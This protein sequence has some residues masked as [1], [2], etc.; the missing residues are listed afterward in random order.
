M[1]NDFLKYRVICE[2]RVNLNISWTKYSTLEDV[3]VSDP[4]AFDYFARVLGNE[5]L[6][7]F[8]TRTSRARYYSMVC[9]GIYICEQ[10]LMEQ[11]MAVTEKNILQAFV[12]YEKYWA[13]SVA[14]YYGG[15]L[16]GRER[17]LRGKKGAVAAFA[18]K[19]IIAL[20]SRY[21]LLSRQLELGGMGAYR[22]SLEGLGLIYDTTLRLTQ[23]GRQLAKCFIKNSSYDKLILK[24]LKQ[25]K[26]ILK[27]GRATVRSFGYHARL[28]GF[29]D[30]DE[31]YHNE[32]QELLREYILNN[33][34]TYMP[35]GLIYFLQSENSI[36]TIKNICGHKSGHDQQ[37]QVVSTYRTILA[38][39]ELAIL[40]N[41]ILCSVI[42]LA[43]G[44]AGQTTILDCANNCKV[45]IG[46][47][48]GEKIRNLMSSEKYSV[49]RNSFHGMDFDT[50][51]KKQAD[52]M[53]YEHFIIDLIHYH[54]NIMIRRRTGEWMYIEGSKVKVNNG[55]D[56]TTKSKGKSYLHDFKIPNIQTIIDDTGWRP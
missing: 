9:Y 41:D 45:L 38:F 36:E 24:A 43:Y 10:F 51:L 34:K 2:R 8:T 35:A 3:S 53:D 30:S 23:Q 4:L 49:I 31:T 55:Y 40:L 11:G 32:E 33:E 14:T 54:A 1:V 18:N 48:A 25:K 15:D 26:L 21:K 27:N 56:Y 44:N 7:H 16:S 50:F 12:M 13:Y 20:D 22:S 52:N 47:A 42:E 6:T 46:D 29:N 39:E 37:K 28:D 17:G 19:K 5:A